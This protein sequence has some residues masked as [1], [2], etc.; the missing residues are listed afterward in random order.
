VTYIR[1]GVS[2]F[3]QAELFYGHG[4]ASALDES[5]YLCLYAL[6]LP[7]D[8]SEKYFDTALTADEKQAVFNL[9]MRRVD[10]RLPAAYLTGE[11]WFAGLPFV[12]NEHVLVPRSPIAGLIE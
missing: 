1:W 11:A 4:M 6:Y 7:H 9:L 12:V 5:V 2:Q 3:H 8:F 10:E